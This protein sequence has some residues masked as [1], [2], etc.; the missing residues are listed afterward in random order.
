MA[1]VWVSSWD[2]EFMFTVELQFL[3]DDSKWLLRYFTLYCPIQ[4]IIRDIFD[5]GREFVC[6]NYFIYFW[7]W[8]FVG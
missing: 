5:I 3:L 4:D 6:W 2:R 1:L 7:C 8:R